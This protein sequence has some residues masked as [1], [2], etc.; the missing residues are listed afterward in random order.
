MEQKK[1]GE[2]KEGSER[3]ERK[4]GRGSEP[5]SNEN[6]RLNNASAVVLLLFAQS[7]FAKSKAKQS[8]K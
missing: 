6:P 8:I 2:R 1:T 7:A 5:I 3:E 4:G